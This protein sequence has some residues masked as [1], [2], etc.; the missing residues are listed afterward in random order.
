M[1]ERD[2][3]LE[4]SSVIQAA[5]EIFRESAD[6][7]LAGKLDHNW[8]NKVLEGAHFDYK[9]T[10]LGKLRALRSYLSKVGEEGTDCSINTGM[11][12]RILERDLKK[13]K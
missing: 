11:W 10:R 5:E 3:Q 2:T 1:A 6:R 13:V 8:D 4:S 7:V 9:R 12:A